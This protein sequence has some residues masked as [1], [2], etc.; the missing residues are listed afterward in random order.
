MKNLNNITMK[1]SILINQIIKNMETKAKADKTASV[2][3]NTELINNAKTD[4]AMKKELLH[5]LT[6]EVNYK[7]K[8][9]A[10]ADIKRIVKMF[11]HIGKSMKEYGMDIPQLRHYGFNEGTIHHTEY[12]K[13]KMSAKERKD[14]PWKYTDK[15]PNSLFKQ[16]AMCE[17]Y[18]AHVETSDMSVSI[19][20]DQLMELVSIASVYE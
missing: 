16:L 19:P 8:G 20:K 11:T 9:D 10:W 18:Y 2:L 6:S 12:Q 1:Q 14:M 7:L 17:Y 5:Q 3:E 13:Q 4:F 15:N